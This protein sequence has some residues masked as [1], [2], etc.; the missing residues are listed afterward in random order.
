MAE[1]VKTR[2]SAARIVLSFADGSWTDE[3]SGERFGVRV[4]GDVIT[5]TIELA[6]RAGASAGAKAG[7]HLRRILDP[8]GIVD[9][10]QISKP[11]IRKRVH[12]AFRA[13]ENPQ[14]LVALA[15]NGK[16]V[17]YPASVHFGPD[18]ITMSV[19]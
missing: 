1:Q 19:G 18:A 12:K 5:V 13:V 14:F 6:R 2:D 17:V 9:S 10:I 11:A 4:D 7:A 8:R 16:S 3:L 15:A